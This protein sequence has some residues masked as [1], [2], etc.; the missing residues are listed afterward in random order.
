MRS[1]D[2]I[3]AQTGPLCQCSY[4]SLGRRDLA[5]L[6]RDYGKPANVNA[7]SKIYENNIRDRI[8]PL[9]RRALVNSPKYDIN[10]PLKVWVIVKCQTSR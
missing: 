5:S 8:S 10:R 9:M 1:C 7:I 6:K 2:S 3:S 4:M